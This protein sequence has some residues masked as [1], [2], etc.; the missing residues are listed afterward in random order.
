MKT[1]LSVVFLLFVLQT[2]SAHAQV[3]SSASADT[4]ER[5]QAMKKPKKQRVWRPDSTHLPKKAIFRSAVVP[6]WGQIYNHSWWKVPLIYGGFTSLG[7]AAHN[8]A[9]LYKKYLRQATLIDQGRPLDPEFALRGYTA[10]NRDIFVQAKDVTKRN[11]DVS[12]ISIGAIWVVQVVEAYV[13]AK[14]QHSYSMDDNLTFQVKPNLI[15]PMYAYTPGTTGFTPAVSL[16][17]HIK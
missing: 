17:I 14:F 9:Q 15:Q 16:V 10:S 5:I 2:F 12:I 6:G 1:A 4:I 8:N 13:Q 7:I 3:D 11:R